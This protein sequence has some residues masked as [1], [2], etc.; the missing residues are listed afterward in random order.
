MACIHAHLHANKSIP[1]DIRRKFLA[2]TFILVVETM[3]DYADYSLSLVPDGRYGVWRL[4]VS[5]VGYIVR[6]L[7]LYV[8][9]LIMTRNM[10]WK[11]KN[12]VL[13]IPTFLERPTQNGASF[14][15]T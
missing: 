4:A 8:V 14:N 15:K 12:L 13:A 2:L 10:K 6:P 3:E 1:K 7:M 5:S 9:M 11:G